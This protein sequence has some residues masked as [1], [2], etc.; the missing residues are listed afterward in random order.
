MPNTSSGLPYPS[1]TDAPD[2]VASIKA[3]ADA[4]NPANAAFK[5]GATARMFTRDTTAS[6]ASSVWAPIGGWG[7]TVYNVGDIANVGS[8]PS[9]V[10]TIGTAGLYRWS[11]TISWPFV[12]GGLYRR[13]CQLYI[14]GAAAG[15]SEGRQDEWV[16]QEFNTGAFRTYGADLVLAVA[17]QVQVYIY[18]SNTIT[19]T[20]IQPTAWSLVRVA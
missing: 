5:R 7:A 9:G 12:S 11:V 3:L 20:N 1:S 19:M 6:L 18:Q 8:P 2:V 16:P 10:C 14:N 13:L 17:D 15:H 4:V